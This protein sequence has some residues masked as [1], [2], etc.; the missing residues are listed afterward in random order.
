MKLSPLAIPYELL[1]EPKVFG[2]GRG[3]S[4]EDFNKAR[5]DAA[6]GKPV[7]FVQDSRSRSAKDVLRGLHCQIQKLQGKLVRFA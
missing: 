7:Q 6:V 4:H 1:I 2:D 3:F 5:F